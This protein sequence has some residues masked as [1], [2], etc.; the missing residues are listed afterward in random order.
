[1]HLDEPT[2]PAPL[3]AAVRE[4]PK[5]DALAFTSAAAVERFFDTLLSADSDLRALKPDAVIAAAK[6]VLA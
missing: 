1:M 4:L 5:Y 6:K 2:D 3:E